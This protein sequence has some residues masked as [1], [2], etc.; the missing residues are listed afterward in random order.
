M[1]L[2]RRDLF[3]LRYLHNDTSIPFIFIKLRALLHLSSIFCTRSRLILLVED[4][5]YWFPST[6]KHDVAHQ[7]YGM[8]YVS[9]HLVF[10]SLCFLF[11]FSIYAKKIVLFGCHCHRRMMI[12]SVIL[13]VNAGLFF[14][15]R[16]RT[17]EWL[18]LSAATGGRS[19]GVGGGEAASRQ[20]VKKK[21]K[22]NRRAAIARINH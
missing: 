1:E 22:W 18:R 17:S 20:L 21:K 16:S 11:F 9:R 3:K 4:L 2:E 15:V 6:R 5:Y 12:D 14:H 7:F 10:L 13:P 8:S 19:A